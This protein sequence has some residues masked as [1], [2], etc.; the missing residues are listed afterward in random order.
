MFFVYFNTQDTSLDESA[1]PHEYE[2][3]LKH[4]KLNLPSTLG[5]LQ[6]LCSSDLVVELLFKGMIGIVRVPDDEWSRKS[7][8]ELSDE[9]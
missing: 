1:T 5:Q 6:M 9:S 3:L 8:I 7:I 2:Q 4:Q